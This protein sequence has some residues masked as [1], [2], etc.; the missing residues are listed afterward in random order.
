MLES[1]K[2]AVHFRISHVWGAVISVWRVR[3]L[4]R[5][6]ASR[7]SSSARRCRTIH[8]QAATHAVTAAD[9]RP[10]TGLDELPDRLAGHLFDPAAD[11]QGGEGD[12]QVGVDRLHDLHLPRLAIAFE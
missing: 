3:R 6:M 4:A 10:A 1:S 9:S 5:R 11:G 8:L 12:A 7:A 2:P